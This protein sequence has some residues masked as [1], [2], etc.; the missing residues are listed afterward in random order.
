MREFIYFSKDGRTSGNFSDLM[1]AGRMDIVCHVIINS[2]F[3]S[4]ESRQD[5]KVHLLLNGPP[6]PPKHIE[7]FYHQDLPISKKD[8]AGLI[9]RALYKYKKGLKA[10]AFPGCN[11]EKKTF[12]KLIEELEEQG[13]KIYVLDKKGKDIRELAREDLE[14]SVFI[15][16]DEEGI[17]K[18][19]MKSTKNIAT[20]ISVGPC[21]YF[22][23]HVVTLVNNEIDRKG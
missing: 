1:Q 16:G 5:V 9:K 17:P 6:D 11:I 8:V 12:Q 3:L 19:E 4:H 10:E 23:S 14:N 15:L 18:R 7:L 20:K 21:M 22:A 13:K 2:F